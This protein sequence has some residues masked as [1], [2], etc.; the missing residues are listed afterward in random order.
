[1]KTIYTKIN[2]GKLAVA[3]ASASDEW[4]SANGYHPFK[5]NP[6]TDADKYQYALSCYTLTDDG[7]ITPVWKRVGEAP[8]RVFTYSKLKI[9]MKLAELK[10]WTATKQMLESTKA[11]GT[12]AYLIEIWNAAQVFKSDNKWFMQAVEKVKEL[13]N[14]DDDTVQKHLRE[15]LAD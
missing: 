11:A 15:C 9:L 1:M 10:W 13:A 6:I 4:L 7:F 8:K 12:D 14:T 3:P 5:Q 2:D